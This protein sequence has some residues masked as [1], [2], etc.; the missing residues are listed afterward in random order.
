[1]GADL[2]GA[3]AAVTKLK[4]VVYGRREQ[5]W[6]A[7]RGGT[8]M[9]LPSGSLTFVAGVLLPLC[10][11][12]AGAAASE[13]PMLTNCLDMAEP[14]TPEVVVPTPAAR[15]RPVPTPLDARRLADERTYRDV[16]RILSTPNSCSNFYGGPARAATAFNQ[17]AGQ[18][19]RGRLD[20]PKI[21]L[22]MSGNYTRYH[23]HTT[24]AVFRLFERAT[25][26]SDGPVAGR[27][28]QMLVGRYPGHTPQAR[29]LA[30]LH[31]LGHLVEGPA[32]GWLLPNDGDDIEKSGR[33]TRLV[34]A[35]CAEQLKAIRD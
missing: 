35:H 4:R 16:Y 12:A 34:E 30:L 6:V 29:A 32:G 24:G 5:P 33:N 7:N 21:A 10:L 14:K 9:P 25:I 19:K 15:P 20:D 8:S 31:E 2:S 11:F 27:A 13:P 3:A 23:D 26:N 22:R 17:F 18:L 28:T 1:M